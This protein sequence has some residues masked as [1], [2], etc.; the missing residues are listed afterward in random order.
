MSV[1]PI[2]NTSNLTPIYDHM[3]K[4]VCM[5]EYLGRSRCAWCTNVDPAEGFNFGFFETKEGAPTEPCCNACSIKGWSECV[6]LWDAEMK[7]RLG[8]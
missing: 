2:S 1:P 4:T 3:G 8:N 7:V 5:L 6:V